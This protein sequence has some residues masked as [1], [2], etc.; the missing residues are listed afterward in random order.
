MTAET[1]LTYLPYGP[2]FLFVDS[3]EEL[4][5]LGI[6][7]HYHFKPELWFYASH[8]KNQPVTPGVILIECMAQIG[9]V[10]FGIYLIS[11][12]DTRREV[13]QTG[14]AL[15]SSEIDFYKPVYPDEKVTIV[16]DIVYFR[17]NKL[18]CKVK[19]LNSQNK[20]VC[21]G[22]LSGMLTV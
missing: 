9:L 15:S 11:K 10:C 4:S 2:D 21:K 19:M 12:E 13:S 7:G 5:E 17:F 20:L 6:K 22:V 3:I 1:L 18:K 8:F 14:L 16:S